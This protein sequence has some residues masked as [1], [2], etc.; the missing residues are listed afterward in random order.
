MEPVAAW[1]LLALAG[2]GVAVA[3]RRGASIAILLLLPLTVT[4]T[5]AVQFGLLR[6]RFSADLAFLILAA[7]ALDAVILRRLRREASAP[8]T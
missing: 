7:F 6:Y 8:V 2:V 3:R 4:I 1:I 5:A